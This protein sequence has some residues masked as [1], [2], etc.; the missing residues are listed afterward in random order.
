M[1]RNG[2][3]T[4]LRECNWTCLSRL[5]RDRELSGIWP[6]PDAFNETPKFLCKKLAIRSNPK[7]KRE[8]QK[9]KLSMYYL[10][11]KEIQKP[12]DE[13]MLNGARRSNLYLHLHL[14][15]RLR[16]LRRENSPRQRRSVENVRVARWVGLSA[17]LLITRTQQWPGRVNGTAIV[18][19]R[20]DPE[21]S[22]LFVI[23]K[24]SSP[25]HHISLRSPTSP[26][27]IF[28]SLDDA[29]RANTL[30]HLQPACVGCLVCLGIFQR[31]THASPTV[32]IPVRE[33]PTDVLP[34]V[35][36]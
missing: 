3:V 19:S 4:Q 5:S 13:G 21:A 30:F 11:Y 36:I 27:N 31:P 35:T 28:R 29:I 24:L 9:E 18:T 10:S 6:S 15:L 26:W 25:G 7:H 2:F 32:Q 14:F 17:T 20:I 33:S 22:I 16:M 34:F 12:S 8:T 23:W 1:N